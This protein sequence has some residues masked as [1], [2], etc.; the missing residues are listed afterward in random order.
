MRYLACERGIA[1]ESQG[2]R[3]I[4][5]K[6]AQQTKM[7]SDLENNKKV[8]LGYIG[9]NTHVL[10]G[11]GSVLFSIFYNHMS[12]KSRKRK[13]DLEINYEVIIASGSVRVLGS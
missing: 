9:H 7:R 12:K 2:T 11:G 6:H 13:R 5:G 4:Q 10:L 1:T 3:T 8:I